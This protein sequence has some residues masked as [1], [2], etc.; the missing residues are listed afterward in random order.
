M[1]LKKFFS[2]AWALSLMGISAGLFGVWLFFCFWKFVLKLCDIYGF[3]V[4]LFLFLGI[5]GVRQGYKDIEAEKE[6]KKALG[7]SE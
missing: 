3:W 5:V 2:N 6:R 1:K 4:P 7:K